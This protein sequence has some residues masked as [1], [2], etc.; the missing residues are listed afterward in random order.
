MRKIAKAAFRELW[1]EKLAGERKRQ[2]EKW[3]EQNHNKTTWLS[4]L[5]EEFGEVCRAVNESDN[6][7]LSAE[8]ITKELIHTAAVCQVMWESGIRNGW[9]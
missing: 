1:E 8:R 4:I 7:A 6:S 5:G 3:G 2:D 9:L